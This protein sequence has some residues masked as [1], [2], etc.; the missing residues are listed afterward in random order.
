MTS[1]LFKQRLTVSQNIV[2]KRLSSFPN[3]GPLASTRY[4]SAFLQ[5]SNAS[6]EAEVYQRDVC[7]RFYQT[8]IKQRLVCSIFVQ[9]SLESFCPLRRSDNCCPSSPS[10]SSSHLFLFRLQGFFF[11]LRRRNESNIKAFMKTELFVALTWTCKHQRWDLFLHEIIVNHDS[12]V[13]SP[14]SPSFYLMLNPGTK[15]GG[16]S[17]GGW[18]LSAK[19]SRYLGKNLL[20]DLRE[21]RGQANMFFF[22]ITKYDTFHFALERWSKVKTFY[23]SIVSFK[24]KQVCKYLVM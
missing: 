4:T 20:T 10:S 7:L 12:A 1:H 23:V 16:G 13:L 14:T 24:L 5:T 17:G 18:M 9:P 8:F 15:W 11:P 22:C 19:T 6:S 21:G 3:A 2:W